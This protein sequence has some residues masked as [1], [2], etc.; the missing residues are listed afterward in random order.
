ME[1]PTP[2]PG[3]T[4]D[5]LV[6]AVRQQIERL[7]GE[8]QPIHPESETAVEL[9]CGEFAI[10]RPVSIFLYVKWPQR[11]FEGSLDHPIFGRLSDVR[12]DVAG[13]LEEYACVSHRP[14]YIIGE[15]HGAA[16]YLLVDLADPHPGDPAIYILDSGDF[17]RPA[18][19]QLTE[20]L[21]VLLE[22]LSPTS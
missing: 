14:Y 7:E 1:V 5:D 11:G 19:R 16:Y 3:T 17:E 22:A 18:A 4:A 10:P 12:L 6:A 15:C 13:E 20:R 9:P 2:G 8:L 21:S